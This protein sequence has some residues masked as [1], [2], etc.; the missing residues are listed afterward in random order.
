MDN[1]G[2]TKDSES[3]SDK[4]KEAKE[5]LMTPIYGKDKIPKESINKYKVTNEPNLISQP[6]PS[7][8]KEIMEEDK[9]RTDVSILSVGMGA[10]VTPE[11]RIPKKKSNMK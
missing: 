5:K 9:M 8:P 2:K 11:K 7:A 3:S 6:E 4:K 10:C 1:E